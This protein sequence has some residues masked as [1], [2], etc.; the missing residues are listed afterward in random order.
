MTKDNVVEF[1]FDRIKNPIAAEDPHLDRMDMATEVMHDIIVSLVELGYNPIED[2]KMISD[3]GVVL[4]IIY[5]TMSRAHGEEHFFH[6]MLDEI[7]EILS[8]MKE[9]L[10]DYDN[11]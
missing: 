8:E 11:H 3:L 7:A 6:E 4:N 1:P 9:K 10:R 2:P 5:A